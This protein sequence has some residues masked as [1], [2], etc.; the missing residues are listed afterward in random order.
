MSLI[1]TKKTAFFLALGVTPPT[2]PAGFVETTSPVIIVP[3]FSKIEINRISGKLNTKTSTTDTC[4]TKTSFDVNHIM[5][6]SDKAALA[7]DTPPEYGLLLRASGFHETIDTATPG[8]ETVTYINGIDAIPNS[9]AVAY[10]DGQKFTLTD[11]LSSGST[12]NL[13]VG[14]PATIINNFSG[15]MDDPIPV[16]EANPTV[17]LTDEV[18]LIVSCADIILFDGTCLPVENAV[19]KM[20]EELQDIYTLGGASCGTKSSFVSDYALELTVDFYVDKATFGREALNIQ[21]GDM[22]EIIVKIALDKTSTEVNGKS[23]VMTMNLA[24]TTVY[25]DSVDKDLLKRSVTFRLMDG[26]EP[27]LKIKTGFFA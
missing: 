20:N 21:S 8:Q 13:K 3:E 15:Y 2:A 27:A 26:S 23:V 4:R 14:E 10:L 12:I 1:N 16:A 25:S 22:K 24:K 11:S 17:T 19:I 6:T 5:R 9:S 7:L 18:P